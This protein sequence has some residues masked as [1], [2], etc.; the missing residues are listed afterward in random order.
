MA[1]ILRFL[2]ALAL[3]VLLPRPSAALTAPAVPA[4][5][6]S[7]GSRGSA[8]GQF[9]QPE[10]VAI[11]PIGRVY[12]VDKVNNRVQ[13][14]D[15]VGNFL[16]QL[17]NVSS[18][19]DT[20]FFPLGVAV[21]R[22]NSVYVVDGN[23][24]IVKYDGAGNFLL[25]WGSFPQFFSICAVAVDD[26]DHVYVLDLAGLPYIVQKF[27]SSGTF[28]K[29]W[30]YGFSPTL[31]AVPNGIAVD[32]QFHVFALDLGNGAVWES[33]TVG[34]GIRTWGTLGTGNGQFG[35]PHG[36]AVDAV[37]NV[38][39]SDWGAGRVQV[40]DPTGAYLA[41]WHA[42]TPSFPCGCPGDNAFYQPEG[43]AITAQGDVYVSEWGSRRV[44]RFGGTG[45]TYVSGTGVA[46]LQWGST[47]LQQPFGVSI[48]AAGNVYVADT[49]N[50]R[51]VE[52]NSSGTLVNQWG[53]LGPGI[54]QFQGPEGLALSTAGVLY[55]ADA[56]NNRIEAFNSTGAYS[57]QWGTTGSGPGNFNTPFGVATDGPNVVDVVD[58]GNNRIQQFDASGTFIAAWGGPGSGNG[59]FNTPY[60]I[61]IDANHNV[62]VA[63]AGNNRIQKFSASG[64]YL[65]QWGSLGSAN[66]QFNGPHAVALD[67]AGNVYV[68]DQ[69]N[70]RIEAF[71]STGIYLAQ[72]PVLGLPTP[73]LPSGQ[74]LSAQ[75]I[76][77]DGLAT[78]AAGNLYFADG[79][80]NRMQKY[81]QPP[82]VSGVTDIPG[83]AGN[84]VR[85]RVQR[86][87]VDTATA[88]PRVTGY[89]IYRLI[90][91]PGT[92]WQLVGTFPATGAAEYLVQ[93][94]TAVNATAGAVI[95]TTFKV[96]ALTSNSLVFFDS[97]PVYGYSTND[98]GPPLSVPAP[99]DL[100]FALAGTWPNPVHG[101]P[102]MVRFT[103]PGDVPAGLELF[104]L[105]GRRI[106]SRQVGALGAGEHV[107]ELAPRRRL[108][109]GVYLLRLK[110]GAN[111]RVVRATVLD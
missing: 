99:G 95:Y 28:L 82:A 51:I 39:V 10:A 69:G 73:L 94:P 63:D 2:P 56:G 102:L 65:A 101:G 3:M 40:F 88:V 30:T 25:K 14:F 104:D 6:F 58:Q 34:V 9:D 61:A 75:A 23:D 71:T 38:Y 76:G 90:E 100:A 22:D 36:I 92:T 24:R 81:V 15:A 41:Q 85:L 12:V 74:P 4:F 35:L 109:P 108:A 97:A 11:S 84:W 49:G 68:S 33:N 86:S 47:V 96:R 103:L 31:T 26:S 72:W 80:N 48:D 66:G 7:W 106:A 1:R 27:T 105:A 78:D 37:G 87:S 42:L 107:V 32:S 19:T 79:V 67:A 5:Q 45:L 50:N 110:Q 54:G 20:L 17:H 43:I 59:Q 18:A 29:K 111:S 55:V 91:P 77:I 52:F 57:T 53:T 83:D 8:A 44:D 16:T 60:G 62:Y 70:N 13:V 98:G 89:E 46:V 93:A 21:G 64:T